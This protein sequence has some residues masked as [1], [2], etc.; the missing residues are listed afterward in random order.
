M[1]GETEQPKDAARNWRVDGVHLKIAPI[2][3]LKPGLHH[4]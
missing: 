4:G 3:K 1:A 2:S